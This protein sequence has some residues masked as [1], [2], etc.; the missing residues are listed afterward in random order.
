MPSITTLNHRLAVALRNSDRTLAIKLCEQGAD[1]NCDIGHSEGQFLRHAVE[2]TNTEIVA[3]LLE[4]GADPNKVEDIFSIFSRLVTAHL[5]QCPCYLE[6]LLI[7][8]NQ[9]R[10]GEISQRQ[11]SLRQNKLKKRYEE[12]DFGIIKLKIAK[13]LVDSGCDINHFIHPIADAARNGL[14]EFRLIVFFLLYCK[15]DWSLVFSDYDEA[16]NALV[17]L[18]RDIAETISLSGDI[19]RSIERND[20]DALLS[21]RREDILIVLKKLYGK[22]FN[23][24]EDHDDAF[25]CIVIKKDMSDFKLV[26]N[27]YAL[28]QK[29]IDNS[30]EFLFLIEPEDIE[31]KLDQ[32]I[33]NKEHVF[34]LILGT[35]RLAFEIIDVRAAEDISPYTNRYVCKR[36]DDLHMVV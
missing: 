34:Y 31:C 19:R 29:S 26:G 1:P 2:G 15:I 27:G 32:F 9:F 7:I 13:M 21:L 12:N 17:R 33:L 14:S 3:I 25:N 8:G 11:C 35:V 22:H 30:D 5:C 23:Y 6:Q 36:R 24:I 18:W 4:I 16:S 20:I 10:H 28:D